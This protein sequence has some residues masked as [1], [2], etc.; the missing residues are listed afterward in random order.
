MPRGEGKTC[1]AF[2]R[3]LGTLTP[4]LLV[5]LSHHFVAPGPIFVDIIWCDGDVKGDRRCQRNLQAR[6][7]LKKQW[8]S[9][10]FEVASFRVVRPSTA[11]QCL[12][13]LQS[14]TGKPFAGSRV[15]GFQRSRERGAG[16]DRPCA[17]R[18]DECCRGES[19]STFENSKWGVQPRVRKDGQSD[20][21]IFDEIQSQSTK[22]GCGVFSSNYLRWREVTTYRICNA[23]PYLFEQSNS[24]IY[25]L[26]TNESLDPVVHDV[27]LI[28]HSNPTQV[29]DFFYLPKHGMTLP[30]GQ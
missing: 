15:R 25:V 28:V 10:C 2:S 22:N 6:S 9:A 23:A 13:R 8:R 24:F 1:L 16:Q 11:F 5:S 30:V 12:S 7:H 27:T 26:P 29:D 3:A 19:P 17:A 4:C 21:R 20:P 18:R 14:N